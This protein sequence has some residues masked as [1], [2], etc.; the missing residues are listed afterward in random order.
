[1][2]TFGYERGRRLKFVLPMQLDAPRFT[3]DLSGMWGAEVDG[4]EF[5]LDRLNELY[6]YHPE[7][8]V[9]LNQTFVSTAGYYSPP[10]T[11]FL[12]G[13]SVQLVLISNQTGTL[14]IQIPDRVSVAFSM[15]FLP[16]SVPTTF[17]WVDY[18]S[19][20]T[21]AG[22]YPY[23]FSNPPPVFRVVYTPS[24]DATVSLF[25]YFNP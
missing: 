8:A 14:K 24:A 5:D 19:Q 10:L 7:Q 23:I 15:G 3:P 13:K 17:A 1:M 20:S 6:I 4:Y 2:Y 9:L 25:A 18:D 16:M 21:S 22:V 12:L 11:P